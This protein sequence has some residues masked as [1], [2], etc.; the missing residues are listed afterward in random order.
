M[1]ASIFSAP[2]FA[3]AYEDARKK[4]E[5]SDFLFVQRKLLQVVNVASF[6][7]GRTHAFIPGLQSLVKC[8]VLDSITH[9]D[10]LAERLVA[11]RVI[12]YRRMKLHHRRSSLWVFNFKIPMAN[13]VV[14]ELPSAHRILEQLE[15]DVLPPDL[16]NELVNTY[17]AN[18][19]LG[20]LPTGDLGCK[21]P[22]RET[23]SGHCEDVRSVSV[24]GKSGNVVALSETQIDSLKAPPPLVSPAAVSFL[25]GQHGTGSGSGQARKESMDEKNPAS[26]RNPSHKSVNSDSKSSGVPGNNPGAPVLPG[27]VAP[28]S[29]G[30]P[31]VT[32]M[33]SLPGGVESSAVADEV[34]NLVTPTININ[35][36]WGSEPVVTK[37]VTPQKPPSV[38]PPHTPPSKTLNVERSTLNGLWKPVRKRRSEEARLMGLIAETFALVSQKFSANEMVN[39]GGMWRVRV[40]RNLPTDWIEQAT[41]EIRRMINARETFSVNAAATMM[42]MLRKRA[43]VVHISDIPPGPPPI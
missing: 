22:S 14:D 9:F 19:D 32:K 23:K 5:R 31:A 2:Q 37:M 41:G 18:L 3:A 43:G 30:V 26:G 6:G 36:E 27:A 10:R 4:I 28:G 1:S 40:V 21:D 34:T 33:V 8:G 13:W 7:Q 42:D 29:A 38:F 11:L 16:D 17:I 35:V 20:I 25:P 24:E 12:E 15:L 39:S